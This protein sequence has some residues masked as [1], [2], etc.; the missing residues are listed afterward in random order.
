MKKLCVLSALTLTA[1]GGG[2]D[3]PAPQ[4]SSTSA[5]P[6][7][8]VVREPVYYTEVKNAIPSLATF[9][10]SLPCGSKANVYMMPTIDANN[11]KRKDLLVMLWCENNSSVTHNGAST[12]V[13]I[14]LLQNND[15]TYRLGNQELFGKDSISLH[16]V[17][18]EHNDAAVGDFNN[19]GKQDIALSPTLEDGR[20]FVIYE[21]GGNNWDSYPIV[22]L[23]QPDGTY[24]FEQLP[25]KGTLNS[26]IVIRENNTDKISISEYIWSYQNQQWKAERASDRNHK[27]D[28][29]T[30]FFDNNLITQVF[31]DQN[32]GLEVGTVNSNNFSRKDYHQISTLQSVK[33]YDNT[34]VGDQ[35]FSLATIDGV[36][37]LM[38]AIPTSCTIPIGNGEILYFV[39][40]QGIKLSEKYTGQKLT[41]TTPGKNG[42]VT[43]ENYYT[44]VLAYRVSSDK[45]TRLDTKVFDTEYKTTY[46][47]SCLDMNAD[48]QKDVVLHRWGSNQEKSIVWLNK[49]SIFTQVS[50][51]KIPN[52][53]SNYHGHHT[54]IADL[55]GDNKAEIIYSPGL[56][57]KEGYA[58]L[59]DDYQVYKAVDPL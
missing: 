14:S 10:K 53:N 24:K 20:Y 2:G 25:Y 49:N 23:S 8:T 19:D 32:F 16:G 40:F 1:C 35:M 59:F 57:Y 54:F 22:L 47:L 7:S 52:I 50:E 29:T 3:S 13:I 31:T 26:V 36:E 18:G 38:P 15:G 55:D 46:G 48:N 17:L 51:N 34:V 11:D 37:W 41:W 5:N 21:G 39:D 56:G 4:N 45:I 28:T 44:K 42:N 6:T 33:V 9:Y 27:I 30:A 58:G 43:W 12:N